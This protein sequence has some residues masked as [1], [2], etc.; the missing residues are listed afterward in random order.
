MNQG[1][2][3]LITMWR[4]EQGADSQ[5][6]LSH[7]SVCAASKPFQPEI[8]HFPESDDVDN[9]RPVPFSFYSAHRENRTTI[10][11]RQC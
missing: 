11:S 8:G 1:E 5:S 9:P 10:I 7:P 3:V 4:R 2:W 6:S